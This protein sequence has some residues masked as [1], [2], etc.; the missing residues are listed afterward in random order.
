MRKLTFVSKIS[1]ITV[2]VLLLSACGGSSDSTSSG[3]SHNPG[4]V[5]PK[6][7]P[8]PT[9]P[10]PTP[11]AIVQPAKATTLAA[12]GITTCGNDLLNGLPCD[13]LS[14]DFKGLQQD[15]EVKA[16]TAMSYKVLNQNGHECVQDLATGLIWEQKTHDN[17]MHDFKHTYTWYSDDKKINGGV[18][19]TKNGG[20]CSDKGKCDTKAFI[21][22]LNEQ[23]YCGY[24]DWRLPDIGELQSLADYSKTPGL[25][26]VFTHSTD[27]ID[28]AYWSS[29]LQS[30]EE[31]TENK[32]V[33]AFD[34]AKLSYS[35]RSK[36]SK[37]AVRAVR[38]N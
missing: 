33:Y 14:A 8:Q 37:Q 9:P 23:K 27:K 36:Q 6:P 18:V 28:A 22:T 21:D 30:D 11:P 3:D 12:T 38:S 10:K 5:Q 2:G 4:T 20:T 26:S 32:Y 13:K 1:A 31:D 16:G 25:N 17:G 24:S 34:F 29:T 35:D 19:G 15:G 7:Q